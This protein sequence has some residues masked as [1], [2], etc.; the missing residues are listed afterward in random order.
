MLI[1]LGQFS[2]LT[3]DMTQY[4]TTVAVRV[5]APD[6]KPFCGVFAGSHQSFSPEEEGRLVPMIERDG[7]D[8]DGK[9]FIL[10]RPDHGKNENLIRRWAYS[11]VGWR[12]GIYVQCPTAHEISLQEILTS[13][14]TYLWSLSIIPSTSIGGISVVLADYQ[15]GAIHWGRYRALNTPSQ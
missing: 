6:D 15:P 12:D 14:N 9:I 5:D 1:D 13:D 10:D 2:P 7:P 4:P 11:V 8:L 3:L